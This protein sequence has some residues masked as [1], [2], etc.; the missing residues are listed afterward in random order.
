MQRCSLITAVGL[1]IQRKLEVVTY[2]PLKIRMD[3][4]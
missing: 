2:I 1:Y 3:R 4:V